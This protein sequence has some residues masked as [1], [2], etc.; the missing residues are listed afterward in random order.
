MAYFATVLS[1]M[2]LPKYMPG[3]PLHG[4]LKA[5]ISAGVALGK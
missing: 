5:N 3:F 2:Q 4:F 1:K